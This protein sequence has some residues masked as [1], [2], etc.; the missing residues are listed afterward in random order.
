MRTAGPSLDTSSKVPALLAACGRAMSSPPVFLGI[1]LTCEPLPAGA[2]ILGKTM[3]PVGLT[4]LHVSHAA[5]ARPH[6][7]QASA[8]SWAWGWGLDTHGLF[9]AMGKSGEGH[10]RQREWQRQNP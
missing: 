5:G 8:T 6:G 2:G 4:G 1:R 9:Q 10:S 7:S 3:A